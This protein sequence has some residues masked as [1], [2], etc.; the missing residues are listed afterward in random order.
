MRCHNCGRPL[1]EAT[2]DKRVIDGGS[3]PGRTVVLCPYSC[4][5]SRTTP[6]SYP[7]R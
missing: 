5:R 3:G 4:K 1:S 7:T 6:P 2:A